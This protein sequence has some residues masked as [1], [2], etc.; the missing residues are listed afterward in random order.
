MKTESEILHRTEI[1]FSLKGQT[2]IIDV[3]KALFWK[4]S[5][6]L[7]LSDLHLGKAAHFRKHG[8]PVP[9]RVHHMDF[10]RLNALMAKYQPKKVV[11]LGDLFH[12][13]LNDEWTDFILWTK[14]NPAV[15]LMLVKGNHDI[16]YPELYSGIEM[17]IV[18]EWITG[19]FHFTH[20]PTLSGYYNLS[21]HVHP[22]I[23]LLGSARQGVRLP[24]FLFSG[25][26]GLFPAFGS[27]TGNYTVRPA[28]G[29]RIFAITDHTVIGLVA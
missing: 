22:G 19:P 29:D 17:D 28:K 25:Q 11:F 13:E 15:E 16:L 20:K 26:S 10:H 21:G 14:D 27:F 12:S 5:E 4:E 6:A 3:L 23:K 8:I 18:D 9:A 2:L 1:A 7:I 24:C